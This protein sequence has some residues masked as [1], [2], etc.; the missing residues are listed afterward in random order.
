MI[1]DIEKSVESNGRF[2]DQQPA[3]DKMLNTKVV[4]WL[5]ETV[6]AG[7]VKQK[8]SGPEGKIVGRYNANPMLNDMIYEV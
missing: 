5:G 3:Y 4:L 1:E 7:Q 2:I 6:V 8:V